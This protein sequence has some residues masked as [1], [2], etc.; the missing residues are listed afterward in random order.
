MQACFKIY[1]G[2]VFK[3]FLGLVYLGLVQDLSRVGLRVC[4]GL[5]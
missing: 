2:L 5:I 1:V 4:L 3:I